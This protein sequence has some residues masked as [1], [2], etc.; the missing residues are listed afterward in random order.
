MSRSLEERFAADLGE[1]F[2]VYVEGLNKAIRALSAA[3]ADAADMKDLMHSIGNT[4]VSAAE[5][6]APYKTGKLRGSIRAGKGKTKAV[7]RAGGAR[8]PYAGVQHYGW[9][10]HGIEGTHFLTQ[11]LSASRARVLAQLNE[12][13]DDI[14]VKNNLK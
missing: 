6:L 14:L 5:P 12:G 7:V 13:L 3:G 1:G 11:G 2:G 10:A 8:Y 4:V 9:P